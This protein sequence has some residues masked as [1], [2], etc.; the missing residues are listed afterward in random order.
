MSQPAWHGSASGAAQPDSSAGGAAQPTFSALPDSAS[1]LTVGFYNVGIQL[2][3]FGGKKW[4]MKERR[5][6]ADIFKA[7]DLH[8]LDLL[9]LSEIGEIGVGIGEKI[10][11]W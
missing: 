10:P 11:G 1:E 6:A 3:E 7:F 5:L 4:K 8:A 2:S 9:C